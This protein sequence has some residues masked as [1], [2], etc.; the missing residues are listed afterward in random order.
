[1]V[2]D[3]VPGHEGTLE[4]LQ[5]GGLRVAHRCSGDDGHA[6]VGEQLLRSRAHTAGDDEAG[7]T[8]RQPSG[9]K[10]GFV[11]RSRYCLSTYDAVGHPVYVDERELL[12]VPEVLAEDPVANRNG[13]AH[14][15]IDVYRRDGVRSWGNLLI[16]SSRGLR[17]IIVVVAKARMGIRALENSRAAALSE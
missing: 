10:A 13:E 5:D 1:V 14:G 11:L 17:L 4:I 8:V 16:G 6:L 2:A 3:V 15:R 7:S 9:Q 12:A